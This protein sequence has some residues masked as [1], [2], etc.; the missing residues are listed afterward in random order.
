MNERVSEAL[1]LL[2][3]AAK[4]RPDDISLRQ[5]LFDACIRVGLFD[6]A[7]QVFTELV[8]IQPEWSQFHF[9]TVARSSGGSVGELRTT[10]ERAAVKQPHDALIWY[11]LGFIWQ[12]LGDQEAAGKAFRRGIA[13]A[14]KFAALH[15]NLGVTLMDDAEQAA[16]HLQ[17]A[18]ACSPTIAEPHL[19]LGTIYMTQ[20]R[21]KA[22]H[23]F[24]EFIRL[25][26]AYLQG[27]TG[28]A[29]LS[30]QLLGEAGG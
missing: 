28:Q 10:F 1:E 5:K 18:V 7:V 29:Q 30:L 9:D 21:V 15:Y 13:A 12:L 26:P 27:Y 25:A 16:E 24:R 4:K 20:D 22:A 6:E 2:R 11:G 17:R 3:G 14:P 19:S 8:Q 23:H